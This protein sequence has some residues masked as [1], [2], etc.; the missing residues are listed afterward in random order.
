LAAINVQREDLIA[1][2]YDGLA[3]GPDMVYSFETQEGIPVDGTNPLLR[4]L[5][6]FTIRLVPPQILT[7]DPGVNVNLIG[8]ANQDLND[9]QLATDAVR[10]LF[11]LNSVSGND[12]A[13][14]Q[15]LQRIVSAGQV[16]TGATTTTERSVLADVNTAADIAFQ[17]EKMLQTPP[18]TLLINPASLSVSYSSIHNYSERSRKGFIFERWGEGQPTMSFSGSTGAFIAGAAAG[19]GAGA[20]TTESSSVSGMQFASKR[21][22]AAWQNFTSLYHFY[23]NNGYIY[24]TINKTEAHL[25]IG[26]LAIDYDQFTYVGHME[27]FD[28]SYDEANPHRVEWSIEFVVDQMYDVAQPPVAVVPQAAPQPNP[29]YPSRFH[30]SF[31]R[32]PD[33]G[34]VS[35]GTRGNPNVLNSSGTEQFAEA[36]LSLFLPSQITSR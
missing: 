19:S 36:P 11:G 8:R 7:F 31:I 12:Q 32:R 14:L 17:I 28:Y 20:L 26:A 24:D 18:L 16:V 10:S 1:E 9:R 23:R 25:M 30:Q 4:D 33:A 21:D 34:G 6:P 35:R 2:R 27:S 13:R 22:S 29:S 15:T 3:V 5:S